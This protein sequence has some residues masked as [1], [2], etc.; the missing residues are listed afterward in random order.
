MKQTKEVLVKENA[1][2]KAEITRLNALDEDRR[3]TLSDLLDSYEYVPEFYNSYS[4]SK[5]K[6]QLNVRD[7][8]GIAFLIG[9]LKA[10]ADYAMVLQSRDHFQK[11]AETL[12]RQL[13]E[14]KNPPP[15]L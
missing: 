12:R 3:K 10:D 8:L 1:I 14:I 13:E 6:R 2:L 7:W 11:E 9:E 5:G 15:I 4:N